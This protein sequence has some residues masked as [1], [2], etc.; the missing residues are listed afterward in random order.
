VGLTLGEAPRR[1][2]FE[3]GYGVDRDGSED[4]RSP[5]SM[6]HDA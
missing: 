1:S 4:V 2:W 5:P 3:P 6:S